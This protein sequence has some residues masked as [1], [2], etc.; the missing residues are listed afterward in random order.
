MA[1]NIIRIPGYL[2]TETIPSS[3]SRPE[4]QILVLILGDSLPTLTTKLGTGGIS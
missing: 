1:I 4:E 2:L 3:L